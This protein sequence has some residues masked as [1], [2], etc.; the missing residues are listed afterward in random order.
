MGIERE[1]LP[2]IFERFYRGDP[3]RG[4]TMGTGLGLSISKHLVEAHGGEIW[5]ESKIGKGS[6]F[7]FS[8]P[9]AAA[10]S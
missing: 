1:V 3:S 2:R 10:A 6:R 7:S 9:K 4:K 8:I 5:A